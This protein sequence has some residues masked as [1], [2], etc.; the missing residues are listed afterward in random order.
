MGQRKRKKTQ[1][2]LPLL[3]LLLYFHGLGGRK[4]D[5]AV[6]RNVSQQQGERLVLDGGAGGSGGS[7]L[8]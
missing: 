5:N 2:R 1:G 4:N 8:S 6:L 7:V 3:S